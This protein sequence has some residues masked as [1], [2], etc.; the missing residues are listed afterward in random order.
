M[1]NQQSRFFSNMALLL[2]IAFTTG[3]SA[4]STQFDLDGIW[5]CEQHESTSVS[6]KG[7]NNYALEFTQSSN[8]VIQ[9]GFVT[10]VNV[11][12]QLKSAISY[13]LQ[14]QFV[15]EENQ[16]KNT[17]KNIQYDINIDQLGVFSNGISGL[18]PAVGETLESKLKILDDNHIQ[19]VHANGEVTNCKKS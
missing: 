2:V 8:L 11:D 6:L 4:N 12:T 9:N 7:E 19:N 1:T 13:E 3:T 15:N 18:F 17:L 10:V 16:F 5:K 14:F